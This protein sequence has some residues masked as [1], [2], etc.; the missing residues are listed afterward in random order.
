MKTARINKAKPGGRRYIVVHGDKVLCSYERV[1]PALAFN[2]GFGG[3]A[4]IFVTSAVAR[5]AMRK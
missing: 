1:G 4:E 3:D 5:R 2:N